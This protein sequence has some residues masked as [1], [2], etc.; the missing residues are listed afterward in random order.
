M[1]VSKMQKIKNFI[2][3]SNFTSLGTARNFLTI[4]EILPFF[5]KSSL[6]I[7]SC[8][9]LLIETKNDRNI[10]QNIDLERVEFKLNEFLAQKNYKDEEIRLPDFAAAIGLSTHQASYYLNK[11]LKTSFNDFI[12]FNRIEEAKRLILIGNSRFTLLDIAFESGFNSITTFHRA[13]LKFT[14]C[15]PKMLRKKILEIKASIQS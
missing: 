12:N 4:A 14:G 9:T 2:V 6:K 11:R 8:S 13:C 7:P 10:L 1:S 15:S 3:K 5:F